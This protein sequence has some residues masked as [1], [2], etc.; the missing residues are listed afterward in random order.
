[1]T[2]K[3]VWMAG[4][5]APVMIAMLLLVAG[6][7]SAKANDQPSAASAAVKIDNFL[8]GPQTITVPV[9]RRYLDNMM[10]FPTRQ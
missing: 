5:A 9:E 1:M 10:T 3:N 4:L 7:P 2:R 6:S 8:L